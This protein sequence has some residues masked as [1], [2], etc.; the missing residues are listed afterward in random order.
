M[1]RNDLR[2]VDMNL[3][4]IFET[5]MFEKNLTRA[6]EK[7]FLGQFP[8]DVVDARFRGDFRRDQLHHGT[9]GQRQAQEV[10]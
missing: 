10:A 7:L 5:L 1:N 6:G 4:V 2:H 8:A 3:L 9:A